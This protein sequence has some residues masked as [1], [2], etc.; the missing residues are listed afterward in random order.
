MTNWYPSGLLCREA[1]KADLKLKKVIF[2]SLHFKLY[3]HD[4][5]MDMFALHFS[6]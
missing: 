1:L 2:A 3:S 4:T 6:R 5:K